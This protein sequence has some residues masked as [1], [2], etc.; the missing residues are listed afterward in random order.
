MAMRRREARPVRAADVIAFIETM[1]FVPEGK[2]VGQP[3]QLAP[4]QRDFVEAIYDNPH[5][6]TRR[7]FLSMGRISARLFRRELPGLAHR[8]ALRLL[9]SSSCPPARPPCAGLRDS[10]QIAL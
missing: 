3:I 5:G 1:C 9:N 8:A 2:L 4:F 10:G 7:G 6:P